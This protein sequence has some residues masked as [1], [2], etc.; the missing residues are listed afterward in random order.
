MVES[1]LRWK[2]TVYRD[3]NIGILLQCPHWKNAGQWS[4][5]WG[6]SFRGWKG[7][8]DLVT[9]IPDP[10]VVTWLDGPQDWK[11]VK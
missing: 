5:M 9:R 1:R 10:V 6:G 11:L 7:I 2:V 4:N 3:G 8:L